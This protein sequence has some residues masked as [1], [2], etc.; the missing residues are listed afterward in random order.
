V[1]HLHHHIVTSRDASISNISLGNQVLFRINLFS[2][3]T[4]KCI[5]VKRSILWKQS[6]LASQQFRDKGIRGLCRSD[7]FHF[8]SIVLNNSILVCSHAFGQFEPHGSKA[9][10]FLS[11]LCGSETTLGTIKRPGGGRV[12]VRG[13]W[14]EGVGAGYF[15][16]AMLPSS[17]AVDRLL[18]LRRN[19]LNL[20]N[21]AS[22]F[23]ACCEGMGNSSVT[24]VHKKTKIGR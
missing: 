20:A 16:V 9:S 2:I 21:S 15:H 11:L 1:G 24:C 23:P 12:S 22:K 4:A 3:S 14:G 7:G 17:W 19:S 13:E 8:R 18:V 5:A 6:F 10:D